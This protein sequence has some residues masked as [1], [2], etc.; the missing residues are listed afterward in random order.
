MEQVNFKNQKEEHQISEKRKKAARKD[1]CFFAPAGVSICFSLHILPV[2]KCV[3]NYL[4]FF[5]G[6]RF[7]VF[8]LMFTQTWN[9]LKKGQR[10]LSDSDDASG[11]LHLLYR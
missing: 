11:N 5:R 3:W 6:R 2:Q 4:P 8:C 7:V 10:F 1:W 9:F